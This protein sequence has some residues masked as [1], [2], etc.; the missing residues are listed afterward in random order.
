MA[1]KLVDSNQSSAK[2]ASA[3]VCFHDSGVHMFQPL[4]DPTGSGVAS[5]AASRAQFCQNSRDEASEEKMTDKRASNS[6]SPSFG[7]RREVDKEQ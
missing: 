6:N 1:A 5:A 7:R 2:Y 4:D 3:E